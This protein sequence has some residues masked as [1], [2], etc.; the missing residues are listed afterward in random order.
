[1]YQ[2]R[3][4]LVLIQNRLSQQECRFKFQINFNGVHF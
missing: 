3:V 4:G 2:V 1:M